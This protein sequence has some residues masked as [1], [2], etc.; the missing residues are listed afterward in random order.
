[1]IQAEQDQRWSNK[2]S[3]LIKQANFRYN[4]T[5]DQLST[6]K[7]RGVDD[8]QINALALGSYIKN[9]ESILITGC[10]GCGKSFLATAFGFQ[11]CRQGYSVAYFNVQKLMMRLKVA[12]L[13]GALIKL[14]EK[15]AKIDLL[16]LDDFALVAFDKNH[17]NDFLEIIEDRHSKKGD[18]YC[19][20][21]TGL[22]MV[23][24]LSRS[25]GGGRCPGQNSP[26]FSSY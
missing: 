24:C 8:G 6:D 14:M 12:R 18:Y 25:S 2:Y 16:I 3:R 22:G 11:G 5:L 19:Q 9:G 7:K 17:Q 23:R 10:A 15:L 20:P 26:H 1:M 13:E 4:A 21:I